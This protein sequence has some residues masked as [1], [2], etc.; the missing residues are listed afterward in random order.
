MNRSFLVASA[1]AIGGLSLGGCA[2]KGFVRDQVATVDTRV[3][4]TDA[5]V[6]QVEGTAKDALD[7]N[8]GKAPPA[9]AG[10][11]AGG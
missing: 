3:N 9:I 1:I 2:T 10:K 6:A 7:R 8:G 5:H 11:G 4:A